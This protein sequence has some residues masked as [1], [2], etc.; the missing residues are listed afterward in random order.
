[1]T[2]FSFQVGEAEQRQGTGA[3]KRPFWVYCVMCKTDSEHYQ[4]KELQVKRR[5]SDFEWLRAKLS[6][7]YPF[8]IIPPVPEK[9][10]HGTVEKF[11]PGSHSPALLEYRQR[12]L[13]KFL[14]RVGAHPYLQNSD[15]LRNFLEQ[16]D[17]DGWQRYVS[18]YDK[19]DNAPIIPRINAPAAPPAG[20]GTPSATQQP[21]GAALGTGKLPGGTQVWED[22]KTYIGQLE[23]SVRTLKERLDSL[24]RR[25]RGTSTALQ[26]F[27]RNFESVGR[28]EAELDNTGETGLS[29]AA[30]SVGRHAG[31]L[32]SI[33][34]AHAS[35]ENHT[36]VEALQYYVGVCEAAKET[37]KRLQSA[38]YNRE[39][40]EKSAKVAL[41]NRESKIA[42]GQ[43]ADKVAQATRELEEANGRRDASAAAVANFELSLRDELRRF[44]RE[45]QYDMKEILRQFVALQRDYSDKM[46]RSWDDL[47]PTVEDVRLDA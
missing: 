32:A 40:L 9:D 33:Y 26:D 41:D 42:K 10:I 12:A 13:R 17:D 34:S 37:L 20:S 36:V 31:E 27:G 38:I 22:T 3:L 8:C 21:Y 11:V 24:V 2:K 25:R 39:A 19:S 23:E 46:K 30:S 44:H 18:A 6:T 1:M 47:I 5:Y 35:D 7:R 14:S 4:L 15:E 43:P 16:A 28:I 29:R 45:K